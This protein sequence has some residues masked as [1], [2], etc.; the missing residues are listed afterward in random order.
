VRPG[1]NRVRVRVTNTG[2]NARG[3]A[4][5]SGLLGPVTLRPH[6]LVEVPLA[7]SAWGS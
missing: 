6:R 7:R 5:A 3:Q 4:L 1:R 2:A